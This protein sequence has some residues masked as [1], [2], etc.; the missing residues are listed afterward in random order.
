MHPFRTAIEA[1]DLDAAVA[2]FSDDVAFR[3]P[4]VFK[5]YRGRATVGAIFE[6]VSRA[7]RTSLTYAKSARPAR[8]ITRSSSRRESAT[9]R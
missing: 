7:S 3:S 5:P 8:A 6:A 9:S 1:R 4:I 2:L